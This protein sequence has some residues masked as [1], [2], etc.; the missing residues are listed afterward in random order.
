MKHKKYINPGV[1]FYSRAKVLWIPYTAKGGKHTRGR[2]SIPETGSPRD[3]A[4]R[5]KDLAPS[6]GSPAKTRPLP[7]WAPAAARA[8]QG[9]EEEEER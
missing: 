8:L 4:A 2:G 9:V 7:T 5:S 6:Y 1:Y 3:P